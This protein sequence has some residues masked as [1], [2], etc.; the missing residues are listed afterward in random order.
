MLRLELAFV[1]EG[2]TTEHKIKIDPVELAGP[3]TAIQVFILRKVV[4]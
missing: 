1:R 2:Y 4:R 3:Y